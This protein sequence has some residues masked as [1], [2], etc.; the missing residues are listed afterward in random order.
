MAFALRPSRPIKNELRRLARKEL[1]RAAK[2]LDSDSSV[3]SV[4]G[5]RKSVKKGR[6]LLQLIR[7]VKSGRLRKGG[8]G[9]L[10]A[11][12]ALSTLRDAVAIVDTFDNLRR[13]HA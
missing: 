10:E 6:A 13:H 8:E 2:C 12:R 9:L 4:H 3:S 5:A 1:R 7:P 11:G